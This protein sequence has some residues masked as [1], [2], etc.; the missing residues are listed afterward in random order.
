MVLSNGGFLNI[1]LLLHRSSSQVRRVAEE[2]Q[3]DV[4][5]SIKELEARAKQLR[6]ETYSRLTP[7]QRLAVARHPNR[8][9]FLDIALNITD[10]VGS[11]Y[12]QPV[13]MRQ[14]VEPLSPSHQLNLSCC[15][16][17]F[18]LSRCS[19]SS[20]TGTAAAWTTRPW[21]AASA[22]STASP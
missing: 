13:S 21:S 16:F 10:K 4:T 6:L 7:T 19:L 12:T 15:L 11:E 18:S 5:E 3:V 8:P 20:C 9:T 1:I 22:P 2:N 17:V 14:L